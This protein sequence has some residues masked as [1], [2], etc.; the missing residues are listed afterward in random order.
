MWVAWMLSGCTIAHSDDGEGVADVRGRLGGE[1]ELVVL[2]P[3]LLLLQHHT[4]H[5]HPCHHTVW[6]QRWYN[7]RKLT[8]LCWREEACT[9]REMFTACMQRTGTKRVQCTHAQRK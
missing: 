1:L 2:A 4:S 8:V 9:S 3:L 7:C 6:V 5:T